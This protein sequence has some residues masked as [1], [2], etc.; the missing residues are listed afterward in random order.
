MDGSRTA[1]NLPAF[2]VDISTERTTIVEQSS[3]VI[4]TLALPREEDIN[5]TLHNT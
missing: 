1:P 3:G 2:F 4:L 5:R